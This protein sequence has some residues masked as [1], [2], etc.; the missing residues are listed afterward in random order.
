MNEFILYIN[1]LKTIIDRFYEKETVFYSDGEW[2]SRR[3]GHSITQE[4]LVKWVLDL[5]QPEED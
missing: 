2:Y 1:T 3:H 5:T 4:E